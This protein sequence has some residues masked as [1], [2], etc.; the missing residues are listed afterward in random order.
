MKF[1]SKTGALLLLLF[2]MSEKGDA[3]SHVDSDS[4]SNESRLNVV[5]IV[6]D[7]LGWTDLSVQGSTYYETPHIDGLA[8]QGI[9]FTDAYAAAAICSPTRAAILT[10]RY[11]ARISITDWIRSRFQGGEIPANK[12]K[13]TEYIEDPDYPLLTPPNP[14]WMDTEEVTIAE[15]LKKEGYK[16]IHIGKWHLG[17]EDW[18]PEKQG[19]DINIGGTDFGQPPSY[20]DPYFKQGQGDIETLPPRKNGEYLTDREA[21]EAVRFIEENYNS[22][23]FLHLNHYAV[24]TPL[25]GKEELIERYKSKPATN[26]KDPVYA[27]MVHSV[28]QAVGKI[29]KKLEE[30]EIDERTLFIF[31][32]DNG[33][34][35]YS[36]SGHATDNSPLRSGKGFPYEGGIRVPLIIRWPGVVE[37]GT[38]SYEPVSSIDLL[39]T[40]LEATQSDVAINWAM[41]GRSLVHHLVS[42]GR[43]LLDRNIL[44]WHFPHYRQG[45]IVPPYSII[46]EGNW[47]LIK[48]WEVPEHELYNLHDDIGEK[49]NLTEEMPEKV[50]ELEKKL[51][52]EL[53]NINARL[54]Q[55]NPNFEE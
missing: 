48:W 19:F 24:H 6:V 55:K 51:S 13:P 29:I 10:G 16:T 44:I 15:L 43:E 17:T 30:L 21:D 34:L 23:F 20:F 54:P 49:H 3:Y 28:D 32:S 25:Q 9:R 41:D 50:E 40:I 7:D 46:R 52:E 26:Q 14:L 11:P 39:P 38:V 45:N 33:G 5:L 37:P 35:E 27:A 36:D 1:L 22:P 31:T 12:Q 53:K 18:Y 47:K 2:F 42:N 8:S 4:D